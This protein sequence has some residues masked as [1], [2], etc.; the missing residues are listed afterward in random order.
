ML[1]AK[2]YIYFD[3]LSLARG[4]PYLIVQPG[5]MAGRPAARVAGNGPRMAGEEIGSRRLLKNKGDLNYG[6]REKD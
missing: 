2:I 5:R 3:I 4:L 6:T 1:F